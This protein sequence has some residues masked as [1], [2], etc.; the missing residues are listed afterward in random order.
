MYDVGIAASQSGRVA[1]KEG[2]GREGGTGK[3][4]QV[5]RIGERGRENPPPPIALNAGPVDAEDQRDP[6]AATGKS[7]GI[8]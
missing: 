1:V 2:E 7:N 5:K 6:R 8:F 3:F 4:T